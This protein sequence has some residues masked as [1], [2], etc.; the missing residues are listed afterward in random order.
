M[1]ERPDR[2]FEK[3]DGGLDRRKA[4]PFYVGVVSSSR[5]RFY[6]ADSNEMLRYVYLSLEASSQ[7]TSF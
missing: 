5:F 2:G 7:V 3:L 4:E 6:S 1:A